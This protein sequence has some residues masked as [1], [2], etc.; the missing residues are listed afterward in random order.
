MKG[1]KKLILK[2]LYLQSIMKVNWT[3]S[4]YFTLQYYI[5]V[6]YFKGSQCPQQNF[7]HLLVKFLS[8]ALISVNSGVRFCGDASISSWPLASPSGTPLILRN[9]AE[10]FH[11][12]LPIC[13]VFTLCLYV[14]FDWCIS[15][16]SMEH[17]QLL[18]L[19]LIRAFNPVTH[20]RLDIAMGHCQHIVTWNTI[21]KLILQS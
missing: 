1:L 3:S 11:L 17:R 15:A 19:V 6:G 12:L 4:F 20:T 2:Y 21:I 10:D 16:C 13:R 7:Y 8:L 14:L 18:W 9:A 5:I